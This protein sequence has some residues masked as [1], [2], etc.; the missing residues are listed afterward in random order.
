MHS[1]GILPVSPQ[2]APWPKPFYPALDKPR[3]ES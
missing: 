2:L 3:E 1:L